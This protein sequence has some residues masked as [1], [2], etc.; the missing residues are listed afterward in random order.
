MSTS[1]AGQASA[2]PP[3][4]ASSPSSIPD[5]QSS[6]A[7]ASSSPVS[8]LSG[9]DLT[10]GPITFTSSVLTIITQPSTTFT[11]SLQTV[12]TTTISTPTQLPSPSPLGALQVRP[13]CIGDGIDALAYGALATLLLPSAVGLLLWVRE[14]VL[15]D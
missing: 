1:G 6:P 5:F 3:A 10:S 8:S 4:T 2:T 9:S 11:S 15:W 7:L 13:V 14:S 12:V